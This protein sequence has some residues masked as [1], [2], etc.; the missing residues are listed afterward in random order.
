MGVDRERD[1]LQKLYF[2]A[3]EIQLKKVNLVYRVCVLNA[4]NIT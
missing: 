1:S 4:K 2:L 3:W